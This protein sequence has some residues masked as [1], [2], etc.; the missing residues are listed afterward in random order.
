MSFYI[1]RWSLIAGRL[2]GRT[3]NDIKNYW[4]SRLAKRFSG[5]PA[6]ATTAE[7]P[8]T[9]PRTVLYRPQAHRVSM[10]TRELLRQMFGSRKSNPK[11][12]AS[13]SQLPDITEKLQPFPAPQPSSQ[14]TEL[15]HPFPVPD[16]SFFQPPST[17][18]MPHPFPVP[19]PSF[20]QPPSIME[21]PHP[22]PGAQP[23]SSDLSWPPQ[24]LHLK[25]L[26]P[27]GGGNLSFN[28]VDFDDLFCDSF[29]WESTDDGNGSSP[30]D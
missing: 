8:P 25:E 22:F 30:L 28:D 14:P 20:S 13:S 1:K 11:P 5:K 24:D 4:N 6:S 2:P 26:A 18:E 7:V 16:P 27:G 10:R 9:L 29:H 15:A 19:E 17:M 12:P 23:S 3:A 21:M